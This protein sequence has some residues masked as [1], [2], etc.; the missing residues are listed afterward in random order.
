MAGL[1]FFLILLVLY[2]ISSLLAEAPSK[3]G[4]PKTCGDVEIPYPFGIG[5]N[6]ALSKGFELNCTCNGTCKPFVFNVEVLNIALPLGQARM[7][8]YISWQCYN[9]TSKNISSSDTYFNFIGT[10]FRFSNT[11]NMFTAIGA[12]TLAYIRFYDELKG[13]WYKQGCV[14]VCLSLEGLVNGSC[15]GIGCCQTAIPSG[16]NYYSVDFDNNFNNSLVSYFSHC[17]YAVLMEA[18]N[19]QFSTLYV[20]TLDFWYENNGLVPIVMDWAI[21][22]GTCLEARNNMSSYACISDNSICVNST[23]G[24]GYFCNCADGY[25]G[26]PYLHGGCKGQVS[27][28]PSKSYTIISPPSCHFYVLFLVVLLQNHLQFSIMVHG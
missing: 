8:N 7:K 27:C 19:F 26:N 10:P 9:S 20:T 13:I 18:K 3:Q 21:G 28:S 25:D 4:C 14:S 16:I 23:N 15:S 17:S 6:C 12:E 2:F 11:Q 5:H 24:P 22:N 1:H